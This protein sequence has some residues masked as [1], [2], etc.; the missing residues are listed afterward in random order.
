MAAIRSCLAYE[1]V[2]ARTPQAQPALAL[3]GAGA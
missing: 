3:Q 1:S 2:A